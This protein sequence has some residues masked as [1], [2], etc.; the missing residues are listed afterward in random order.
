MRSPSPFEAEAAVGPAPDGAG[1]EIERGRGAA[2]Q[3]QLGGAGRRALL[4]RGE[5]EI[6]E[7]HGPLQLVG[8]ATGQKDGGDMGLDVLDRFRSA[9]AGRVL[10]EGDGLGLILDDHRA[11]QLA[12]GADQPSKPWSRATVL[13]PISSTA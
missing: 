13:M 8:E 11:P 9:I 12:L 5:I 7:A 2:V 4:H 10:Q 3:R 6:A 1:L